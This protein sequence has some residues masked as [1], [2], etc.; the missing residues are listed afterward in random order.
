MC[1][2]SDLNYLKEKVE[3]GADFIITQICFSATKILQFIAK[4]RDAGI[5]VPIIPGIFIPST[6]N[7]LLSMCQMCKIKNP[8][9]QYQMYHTLKDQS[10]AFQD[11][12][13]ENTVKLLNDLFLNG[14]DTV[15]GV[16]FFTLNNFELVKRVASNF[17]FK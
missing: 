3:A 17:D 2:E 8:E 9:E 13:V 12:A 5:K 4:C 14:D 11:Y 16:H 7:A 10:K 1:L 15:T 6:Y